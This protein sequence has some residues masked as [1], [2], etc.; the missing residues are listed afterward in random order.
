[1]FLSIGCGL[2]GVPREHALINVYTLIMIQRLRVEG[3]H[4]GDLE[5]YV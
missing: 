5:A 1:V 3:A 2:Y 4:N